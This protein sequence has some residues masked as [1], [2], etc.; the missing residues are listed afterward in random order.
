[1]MPEGWGREAKEPGCAGLEAR[2]ANIHHL[3]SGDQD[4]TPDRRPNQKTV[5][6]RIERG[7]QRQQ[8]LRRVPSYS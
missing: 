2:G 5:Q 7:K 8:G 1:M 6:P 3:P 4:R